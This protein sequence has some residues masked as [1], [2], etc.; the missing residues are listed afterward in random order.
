MVAESYHTEAGDERLIFAIVVHESQEARRELYDRYVNQAFSQ[1][2]R[3][4]LCREDAEEVVQE[5]FLTVF[6]KL[7]SLEDPARFQ[8]WLSAIV[9]NRCRRTIRDL[10]RKRVAE[11]GYKHEC[12]LHLNVAGEY[13]MR[14]KEIQIIHE[15]IDSMDDNDQKESIRLFYV[16]GLSCEKIAQAQGITVTNVT[17]RLARFRA[18]VQKKLMRKVLDLRAGHEE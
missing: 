11:A 15:L 18:R 7:S 8:G 17:S 13:L 6:T 4:G 10:I 2:R 14:E 5:V 3:F 1:C 12:E 16:E 9:R